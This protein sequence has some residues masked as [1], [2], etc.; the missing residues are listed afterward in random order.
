MVNLQEVDG[1][2]KT[3]KFW[4]TLSIDYARMGCHQS[5]CGPEA[6]WQHARVDCRG[7]EK[8]GS[9]LQILTLC[10]NFMELSIKSLWHLRNACNYTSVF[11][12]NIWQKYLKTLRQQTEATTV[13]ST[14]SHPEVSP[15]QFYL[16]ASIHCLSC[17]SANATLV[18]RWILC[19]HTL[20]LLPAVQQVLTRGQGLT[21]AP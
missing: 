2:T 7:L 21:P 6:N 20:V 14:D 4:Q 11:H 3:H 13:Y 12:S 15:L 9:T 5:G 16:L 8:E 10:I 17:Q 1:Q 19:W 18:V